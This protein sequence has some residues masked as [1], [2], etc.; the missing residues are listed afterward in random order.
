[1]VETQASGSSP[2]DSQKKPVLRMLQFPASSLA[3]LAALL[4]SIAAPGPWPTGLAFA[5]TS[6]AFLSAVRARGQKSLRHNLARAVFLILLIPPVGEG[7]RGWRVAE[8]DDESWRKAAD[9][10]LAEGAAEAQTLVER[11][12]LRARDR[13]R[14]ALADEGALSNLSGP[15]DIAGA[16]L[17]VALS[18]WQDDILLDWSGDVPGPDHPRAGDFPLIVD[19]GYRRFLSVSEQDDRGRTAFVDVELGITGD[20]FQRLGVGAEPGKDISAHTGLA[21]EILAEA[22]SAD[23]VRGSLERVVA[24]PPEEPWIWLSL[25]SPT[26]RD[27]RRLGLQRSAAR[28]SRWI[29]LPFL[30]AGFLALRRWPRYHESQQGSGTLELA[31]LIFLPLAR[32]GVETTGALELALQPLS[33]SATLLTEPAY[34]ATTWGFG[35]LHNVLSFLVSSITLGILAV[36]LL[37]RWLRWMD[38]VGRWRTFTL[39]LLFLFSA[40]LVPWCAQ[41]QRTVAQ[42]ANAKLIGLDAPF[43]TLPFLTL[44]FAMLLSLLAP[45][46]FVLLGW[47]RWLRRGHRFNWLLVLSSWAAC[48]VVGA[49]GDRSVASTTWPAFL[50][51][52]GWVIAPLLH[53]RAFARRVVAALLAVL[54]LAGLQSSGLNEVY[55]RLKQGVQSYEAQERM[56]PPQNWREFLLEDLLREVAADEAS[57]DWISD[58]LAGREN[59]AFELWAASSLAPLRYASRVELVARDGTILS[60]FDFGLPYNPRRWKVHT[61]APGAEGVAVGVERL[62]L[63][64][65][66]GSFIVYRGTLRL[67]MLRPQSDAMFL[68][69]ELPHAAP[70]PEGIFD[71]SPNVPVPLGFVAERELEP[72]REFEQPALWGRLGAQTVEAASDRRLLGLDRQAL[73]AAGQWGR[74]TLDGGRYRLA[75]FENRQGQGLV[76][77]FLEPTLADRILD[78]SRLAALYVSGGALVLL[79]LLAARVFRPR[80]RAIWPRILGDF[81]FQERLLGAI[82]LVVLLPVILSGVIQQ[83][84][85]SQRLEQESLSA[86]EQRLSTAQDLLANHVDDIAAALMGGEYVQEVLRGGNTMAP[87]AVGPFESSQMMVFAQDGRLLLDESLRDF[88]PHEALA[89]LDLVDSGELLLE[90]EID[91]WYVGRLYPLHGLGAD[92]NSRLYQV[93]VRRQ[94]TDDDLA[95]IARAAGAELTLFDGPWAVVSSQDHLLRAGLLSPVLDNQANRVLLEGGQ[96]R[97]VEASPAGQLMVA[98]GF[99]TLPGPGEKRRG[100]LSARLFTLATEAARQ[101]QRAQ[102]FYFGLSS[103]A[104]ILAIGAGLLLSAR[105]VG[106]LRMLAAAAQRVGR[107]ELDLRL[108]EGASDE[109]GQLVQSFNQMTEELRR[110][111]RSLKSRRQFLEAVLG[112]LSAGVLVLDEDFGRL[113]AN[114]SATRLLAG[115]DEEMIQQLRSHAPSQHLIASEMSL[116]TAEGPRTLRLVCERV[117]LEDESQGY[118]V[119]FDDVTE[120]LASRRLT[121]YA[122]MARQVAHEVKNPLTPIQLAAQMVRQACQDRHPSLDQI[123]EDNVT[124]IENQVERLRGIA[125]EFSLLGRT[126]PPEMDSIEVSALLD[127]VRGLY[128]SPDGRIVLNCTVDHDFTLRANREAILKV[129]TNLVENALQAMGG[130]GRVELRAEER[131]NRAILHLEDDGP[132][133]P[134]EV[135]ERLFE[136]YF[137]TKSTGTGL[138]L[139]ICRTLMEKMGGSIRLE[140]R[141]DGTGAAAILSL[142]LGGNDS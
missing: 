35:L 34:F 1:M 30:A 42:N 55:G 102:L 36:L 74:A 39:F 10:H 65:E 73:P 82:V 87:R 134:A 118:L 18:I 43:F 105:I 17:E 37:P 109:I 127:E 124:Q 119:L 13:A 125:S 47:E 108:A 120:L 107:G 84:H 38:Q 104:F 58:P 131:G 6:V 52:L 92:G 136:P 135:Q 138:G 24:I 71:L 70:D 67:D 101:E 31:V 8:Q 99:A 59:A 93:Y 25:R 142:S 29:F 57:V 90:S 88:E 61:A 95:G 116:R 56:N 49:L 54:W 14:D 85:G 117:Q 40:L 3:A 122:E 77:A 133:I 5:A 112:N 68:S 114:A 27:E 15:L 100:V 113:E 75:L 11:L 28:L 62:H 51:P 94:L 23:A 96:P 12:E 80:P 141:G 72:R 128:P 89:F 106:P 48:I 63:E 78:A 16:P 50:A 86:V 45:A 123:V 81:G 110:G 44:H 129:L 26:P 19:H 126:D 137:S 76:V 97:L 2:E 79:V 9:A 115:H 60:R 41:I 91:A 7:L 66:R 103:L 64:T 139:V 21:V 22:P 98:T 32:W 83:K 53:E 46:G 33:G 69:V 132:G 130:A 121:L 4:W 20:L 111:Q 140:N